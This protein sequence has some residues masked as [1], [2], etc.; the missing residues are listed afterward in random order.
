VLQALRSPLKEAYRLGYIGAN[1]GE[2]IRNATPTPR[3]TGI[4]TPEEIAKV[5]SYLHKTVK[6]NTY[7]RMFYLAFSLAVTT[8]M[9]EGEIRALKVSDISFKGDSAF[10]HVSRSFSDTDGYK[11]TKGKRS[12]TT[13][14]D[15]ELGHEIL[16]FAEKN[17]WANDYCFWSTD[18]KEKPIGGRFFLD[19]FK[20]ALN[21][22]GINEE[23]RKKRN[24]KFHSLR[25]N[26]ATA[27]SSKATETTIKQVVGHSSIMTTERYYLHEDFN[28][29]VR[30][31]QAR[32][33]T[34]RIPENNN[35]KERERDG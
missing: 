2:Q 18:N 10:I 17:P 25:G 33:E 32:R 3:E 13:V 5:F 15:A 22:I 34:I 4:L 29:L 30:L 31:N 9:R 21:A 35:R 16:S 11:V 19:H 8:G 6:P 14:T 23:E 12:R 26:F 24:L 20:E 28:E 27:I 1:I 7:D